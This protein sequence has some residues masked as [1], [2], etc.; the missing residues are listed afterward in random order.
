[1]NIY[2]IVLILNQSLGEEDLKGATGRVTDL[3][4]ATGGEVLKIDNWGKRRLAF[5]LNKQRT[6]VYVHIL[7]KAPTT[8][9]G[10]LE[11][12]FKVFDPVLKF[13][14]IR[15]TKKQIAALPPEVLG[16]P[17]TPKEISSTAEPTIEG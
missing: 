1:M 15:L 3:I 8:T 5:E 2:E 6:G 13:M 7:F 16:V 14:V 17:V 11:Q 10:K 9:V 4:A 12:F